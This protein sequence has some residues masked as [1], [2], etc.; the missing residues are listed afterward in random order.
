M[1]GMD[2]A[3]TPRQ[4]FHRAEVLGGRQSVQILEEHQKNGKYSGFLLVSAS[5]QVPETRKPIK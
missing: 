2:H 1:I 4:N 5:F 3:A